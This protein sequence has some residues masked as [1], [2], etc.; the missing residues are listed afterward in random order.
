M[1]DLQQQSQSPEGLRL[2][3][4][5]TSNPILFQPR[6]IQDFALGLAIVLLT[7]PCLAQQVEIGNITYE[8]KPPYPK[9]RAPYLG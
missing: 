2:Q 8:K 9:A 4:G 6:R 5:F 1:V 7:A 3:A